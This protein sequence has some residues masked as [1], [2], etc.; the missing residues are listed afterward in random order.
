MRYYY[1]PT[2][3]ANFFKA[4]NTRSWRACGAIRTLMPCVGVW[5]GATI[6]ENRCTVPDGAEEVPTPQPS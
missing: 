2:K 3:I 6:L 4:D 1:V 5:V